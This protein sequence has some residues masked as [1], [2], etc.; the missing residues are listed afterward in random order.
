[1][2]RCEEQAGDD[3]NEATEPDDNSVDFRLELGSQQL[4]VR[5]DRGD[6]GL[7]RRLRVLEVLR[8]GDVVVDR[9]EDFGGDAL[10]L[11]AVDIGVGQRVGQ[12]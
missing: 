10:G 2:Q 6:I 8:G 9:V 12:G 1:M 4:H 11:L 3:H 5:P 7:Q